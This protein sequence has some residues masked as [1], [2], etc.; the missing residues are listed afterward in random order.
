MAHPA[1]SAWSRSRC[2]SLP[3]NRVASTRPSP[4]PRGSPLSPPAEAPDLVEAVVGFR[5][6]RL[7]GT[8]LWSTHAGGPWTSAAVTAHCDAHDHV[9][10]QNGCTCGIHAWYDPPPRGASAATPDLVAGAII[11]W[12]QIELHAHGM[13]GQHARIVAFA[14]PFSRAGKRRRLLAVAGALGVPAVPA[15]QLATVAGEHGERI[16]PWMRPPD[17]EPNKRKAPG[18][19]DAARLHI[20]ADGYPSPR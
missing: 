3:P 19:P 16:A 14:L 10:P 5:Q 15:R 4:C 7:R 11:L 2:R 13:R 17:L 8:E 1:R 6:W 9:A 18:T 12:G 20:V